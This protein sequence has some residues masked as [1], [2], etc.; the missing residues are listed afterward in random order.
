MFSEFRELELATWNSR[1]VSCPDIPV[2]FVLA[3]SICFHVPPTFLAPFAAMSGSAMSAEKEHVDKFR[4]LIR[5][6][7][8]LCNPNEAD[9]V[10][11]LLA[12]HKGAEEELYKEICMK[13]DLIKKREAAPE[14]APAVYDE[15]SSMQTNQEPAATTAGASPW[16]IETVQKGAWSEW[17]PSASSGSWTRDEWRDNSEE[18]RRFRSLPPRGQVPMFNPKAHGTSVESNRD[19]QTLNWGKKNINRFDAPITMPKLTF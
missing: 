4:K 17:K 5:V 13:F 18:R 15:P 19:D 2:T 9:E 7:Y 8:D 11:A 10:E 1:L 16:E 12:K 14:V 6:A 3:P